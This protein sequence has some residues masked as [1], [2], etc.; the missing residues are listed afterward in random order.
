MDNLKNLGFK[1]E[2]CNNV[3]LIYDGKNSTCSYEYYFPYKEI[4][5]YYKRVSSFDYASR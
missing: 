5:Y 2:M 1:Y 3:L 4:A